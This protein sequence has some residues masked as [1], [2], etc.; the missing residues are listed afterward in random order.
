MS[1]FGSPNAGLQGC[2]QALCNAVNQRIAQGVRNA[3]TPG[4][5]E[6]NFVMQNGYHPGPQQQEM[7]AAMD[8]RD[9]FTSIVRG[10][11]ACQ[12]Q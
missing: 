4:T 3:S 8:I 5:Q 1:N 10:G 12:S 9:Y 11:N 7:S 6:Y 2:N